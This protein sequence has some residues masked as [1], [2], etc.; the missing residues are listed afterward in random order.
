MAP[1]LGPRPPHLFT[2]LFGYTS[3]TYV[4]NTP[5][6]VAQFSDIR[7]IGV[8]NGTNFFFV[9]FAVLTGNSIAG[10]LVVRFAVGLDICRL[11]GGYDGGW[12]R[13]VRC[14]RECAGGFQVD[15]G[16]SDEGV[17]KESA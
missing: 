17:A 13:V 4:A 2:I 9:S 12:V 15:G 16:L 8:R 1:V 7:A 10:A 11:F 5:A 3:G 14:G 6:V